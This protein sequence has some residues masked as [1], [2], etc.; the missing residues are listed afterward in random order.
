[1]VNRTGQT[2]RLDKIDFMLVKIVRIYLQLAFPLYL[3]AFLLFITFF[4]L[5]W[6]L[7]DGGG[8]D[9]E[10][11]WIPEYI[12]YQVSKILLMVVL[13][14]H[15]F[16]CIVILIRSFLGLYSKDAQNK[17]CVLYS[18]LSL[19]LPFSFRFLAFIGVTNT[20]VGL[21]C[22]AAVLFFCLSALYL[23]KKTAKSAGKELFY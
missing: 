1:M 12:I 20:S 6:G 11:G 22:V 8:L 5:G 19:F 14:F 21:L 3:V 7:A 17:Y 10:K 2:N 9:G 4:F 23:H 15:F 13:L 16:C 18:K